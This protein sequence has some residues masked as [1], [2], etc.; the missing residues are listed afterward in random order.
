MAQDA[1]HL[2]ADVGRGRRG[3]VAPPDPY[4]DGH[5]RSGGFVDVVALALC[6]GQS[7][8]RVVGEQQETR[9]DGGQNRPAEGVTAG[10]AGGEQGG[11]RQGAVPRAAAR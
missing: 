6:L 10:R 8:G 7:G 1:V 11:G 4:P 9:A 5:R 3:L 2:D